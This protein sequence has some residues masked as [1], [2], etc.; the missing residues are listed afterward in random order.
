MESYIENTI[1]QYYVMQ[2]NIKSRIKYL[3]FHLQYKIYSELAE[4]TLHLY[5]TTI[6][7]SCIGTLIIT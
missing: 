1:K 5:D 3:Y 4:N 6:L 2:K 7:T